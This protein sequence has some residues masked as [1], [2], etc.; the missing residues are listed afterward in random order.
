MYYSKKK[1][2][3]IELNSKMYWTL[4]CI[5]AFFINNFYGYI[6]YVITI[7]NILP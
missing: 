5:N 6:N 1:C 4:I 3:L 2:G 7:Y